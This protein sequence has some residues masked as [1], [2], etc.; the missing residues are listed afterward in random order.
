MEFAN[1]FSA[2]VTLSLVKKVPRDVSAVFKPLQEQLVALR[3]IR[4]DF[5]VPAPVQRGLDLSLGLFFGKMFVQ[6]IPEK[7]EGHGAVRLAGKA[8]PDLLKQVGMGQ[9]GV[10]EKDFARG[11]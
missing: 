2:V 3:I 10:A 1:W 11:N 5:A 7:L 4:E 9:G 6:N 8:V